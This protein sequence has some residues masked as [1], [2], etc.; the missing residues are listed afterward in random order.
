MG[1]VNEYNIITAPPP[2]PL[3]T[4]P[5]DGKI[6][7]AALRLCSP[8]LRAF[9][10]QRPKCIC[11]RARSRQRADKLSQVAACSQATSWSAEWP[12]HMTYHGR[13]GVR[14]VQLAS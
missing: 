1:N 10:L 13:C 7:N 5:T 12:A 9:N 3:S 2:L 14:V 11:L 8:K 4:R 6:S